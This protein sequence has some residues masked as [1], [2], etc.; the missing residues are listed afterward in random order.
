MEEA[1]SGAHTGNYLETTAGSTGLRNCLVAW[2]PSGLQKKAAL[3]VPSLVPHRVMTGGVDNVYCSHV[4]IQEVTA[5]GDCVT[6]TTVVFLNGD[7]GGESGSCRAE[8][9]P[10]VKWWRAQGF[11]LPSS[12]ERLQ[13]HPV[14][15]SSI[16]LAKRW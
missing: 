6:A 2:I 16:T 4:L 12:L 8:T 14:S 7:P 11:L 5:D 1:I 10:R 9:A 3:P 15:V 13:P